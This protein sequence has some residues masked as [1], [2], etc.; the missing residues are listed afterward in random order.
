MKTF[1]KFWL[2]YYNRTL[3]EKGLISEED[4]RR[5][6]YQIEHKYGKNPVPMGRQ[7]DNGQ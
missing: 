1:N 5:L 6:K 3:K 2:L 7:R 4:Y